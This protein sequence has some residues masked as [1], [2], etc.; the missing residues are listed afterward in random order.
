MES[1]KVAWVGLLMFALNFSAF[2]QEKK[3]E[4]NVELGKVQD[5]TVE[6]DTVPDSV[7]AGGK[8]GTS[9]DDVKAGQEGRWL[10]IEAP[11]SAK[12]KFTPEV[13]F[14]FYVEGYEVVPAAEGGKASE[15]YVV[16]TGEAVYRDVPGG[17]KQYAAVFLSPASVLR[18]AGLKSGGEQDWPARKMNVK[19]EAFE[20]GSPVE[21]GLDLQSEK[22][23]GPSGRGGKKDPEWNKNSEGQEVTGALLPICDTPFWPK[24]YKRYPQP[25][26]P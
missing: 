26:R 17:K 24:D 15:K 19:V 1:I 2:S 10:R 16:L 22:E 21:G 7:G 9:L 23:K 11:F 5:L 8:S 6:F 13:K 20:G 14:K 25:K 3:T 4:T 12:K 18:F